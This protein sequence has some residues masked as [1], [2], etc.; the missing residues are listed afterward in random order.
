M[1]FSKIFFVIFIFLFSFFHGFFTSFEFFTSFD[2][3]GTKR[4]K[5]IFSLQDSEGE[6]S[7][8]EADWGK[9]DKEALVV[10]DLLPSEEC[11]LVSGF[12]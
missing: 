2:F 10:K 11:W 1:F 4:K 5:G 9:N 6:S 12:L 7:S 8:D 3:H